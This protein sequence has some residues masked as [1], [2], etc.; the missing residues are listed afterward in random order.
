M[1]EQKV[2][3]VD[4]ERSNIRILVALLRDDYDL[5]IAMNGAQALEIALSDDMDLILLDVVMPDMDGYEVCQQLKADERTQDVPV[6]FATSKDSQQ[7]EEKGLQIGAVDYISKPYRLPIIKARVKIHLEMKRR[8]DLLQQMACLDG[9]TGIANRRRFDDFMDAEW[10][11][12]MRQGSMM[13]VIL[14]DVDHFKLFNDHY[15]HTM[16]DDCLTA[17][18]KALSECVQRSS[19]LVARYGGEEFVCVLTEC[20]HEAA[21]KVAEKLR[22]QVDALSIPHAYSAA[23]HVTISLG[24][25]SMI[26]TL[27]TSVRIL[28][29]AADQLLYQAKEGGRNQVASIAA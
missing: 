1:T 25:A 15:G 5:Y 7:S 28:V 22:Q 24:V 19:D 9:L 20:T 21:V 11:R 23:K 14:M 13:A 12:A 2:L 18:A 4:D 26:P 16:G 10:R 6:I 17:V 3:I 29:E 27:G 8:G